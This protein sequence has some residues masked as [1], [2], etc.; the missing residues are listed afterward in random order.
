MSVTIPNSVT[1][2]RQ[3]TFKGCSSLTSVIIPNSV[4]TIGNYAFYDCSNLTSV[5]CTSEVLTLGFTVFYG[6]TAT[7]YVPAASAALYNLYH[8]TYDG[9]QITIEYL[10]DYKRD[11][12]VGAFGTLCLPY[13]YT[14]EGA[15]LYDIESIEGDKVILMAVEGNQG[16]ANTAYIYQASESEQNFP[17]VLG[18][19]LNTVSVT[20]T[21]GVLSSP[22]KY[23]IVPEGSYMLQTQDSVQTFYK[24][25]GETYIMPHRAYLTPDA[26]GSNR[27]ALSL[28]FA[29]NED[30]TGIE[31][32]SVIPQG[33]P[34]IYDLNGR[35]ISALQKGLN[36]VDGAKVFVK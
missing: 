3:S 5:T 8:G 23:S 17:Y 2:I 32:F 27:D 12:Q 16:L 31:T 18:E 29:S 30:P 28:Q 9:G 4:T 35:R 10:T 14:P 6:V 7:V 36:I 11:T 24:V 20:V 22:A 15:T 34:A 21:T 19:A 25:E 13:D 33:A 1:E 26:V